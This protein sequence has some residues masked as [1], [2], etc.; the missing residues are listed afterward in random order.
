MS[1][2]ITVI[3]ATGHLGRLAV[4]AL[5]ER[6]VA[7]S[8]IRAT[9][10]ATERL[11]DLADRGVQVLRVD[12][13]DEAAVADAVRG[14]ASVLLVSGTEPGR[15]EQHR[16]VVE[17]AR[18][19]AVQIGWSLES[20]GPA[21]GAWLSAAGDSDSEARRG[22]IA[23]EGSTA[24]V[25]RVEG[26]VTAAVRQ[27]PASDLT[28]V[29]DALDVGPGRVLVWGPPGAEQELADL[30]SSAGWVVD[31]LPGGAG[32]RSDPL[33]VAATWAGRALLELVPPTLAAQR[34]SRRRA[35][36]V[37]LW[38]TAAALVVAAAGAY[39]WGTYRELDAVSAERR[40]IAERV[41]PLIQAQDSLQQLNDRIQARE[42]LWAN[43][44]RWTP[45]LVELASLLPRDSHLTALYASGDTVEL[46]AAGSRAGEAIQALRAAGL[47]RDVRLQGVVERELEN[48][49]TVIE[50]FRVGAQ[51]AGVPPES[52]GGLE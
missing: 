7:P 5:L 20:I 6:G 4:E 25:M 15:V 45:V 11:A 46:E 37:R 30:S 51:L 16:R 10:R 21:H 22:I 18:E 43:T 12:R 47:F 52:T 35:S 33:E 39:V 19:A 23:I 50:R 49:E 8:D 2:T 27:V 9:G 14:A 13:D 44:P 48:G 42:D 17:A 1:R 3:G 28:S 26:R 29:A 41:R 32:G 34:D 38:I 40:E 24:H 31:P 36:A